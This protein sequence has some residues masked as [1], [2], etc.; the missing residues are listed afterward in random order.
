MA[1]LASRHDVCAISGASLSACVVAARVSSVSS[2]LLKIET[3]AADAD[4]WEL[5]TVAWVEIGMKVEW[6]VSD[7]SMEKRKRNGNMNMEM[8]ICKTELEKG[9]F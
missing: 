7:F 1:C 9:T 3:A 8:E 2:E 6:K 4:R 5:V